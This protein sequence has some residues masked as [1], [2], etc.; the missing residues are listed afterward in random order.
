[1]GSEEKEFTKWLDNNYKAS[2]RFEV[3]WHGPT[4]W[5][6]EELERLTKQPFYSEKVNLQ[7]TKPICHPYLRY[8]LT[9]D[10]EDELTFS[11]LDWLV[12]AAIF[13]LYLVFHVLGRINTIIISIV[14]LFL[15]YHY[16][17][18]TWLSFDRRYNFDTQTVNKYL[19]ELDTVYTTKAVPSIDNYSFSENQLSKVLKKYDI[20]DRDAFLKHAMAFDENDNQYLDKEELEKAA[21]AFA[22]P[23]SSG[24]ALFFIK[25]GDVVKQLSGAQIKGGVAKGQLLP[26]DLVRKSENDQWIPL[27]KVKGLTFKKPT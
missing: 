9:K 18:R 20:S 15:L 19:R 4:R 16:P 13:P 6:K 3:S 10:V 8:Q 24:P 23:A 11:N 25:R 1:M 7:D 27:S 12:I 21:V 5:D 14:Y 22:P 2:F 17:L 26:D